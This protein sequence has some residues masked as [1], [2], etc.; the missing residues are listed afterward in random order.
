MVTTGPLFPPDLIGADVVSSF[1]QG[2][3]IRPLERGDY[4]KGFLDCLSVLSDVG[5]VSQDQF[6]ERFDWMKIQGQGVHFHVVIEHENRIVGTGAIIVERKFIHNLGLI[7]HI[8]EIAIGKDFQGKGLGLKLLA[9]LS[10][11]AKNVGCYKTTLGT[12]P[13]NEPFYVKCGYNKSGNIMNQ[14][15]PISTK[16]IICNQISLGIFTMAPHA[17]QDESTPGITRLP[18]PA[19][20]AFSAS[21]PRLLIIGAGNRGKAYAEAIKNASNGVIVGVVEPIAL[22]RRHLGRKYI[23]GTRE[24]TPGEEFSDWPE[25]VEWELSR[26]Q[27][28][29]SGA[30][31]V[32]EGVD[33]VF[34]CVQDGMHK[35]V[36]LGLAPL[37][38]HIMCE[39]P[40]APNLE[41]C[42]AIYN[43]L[44]PD[45]SGCSEK[46]FAI[47]HVLRYSPHNI[48]MR[49][50]LLEDKLIGD[51]MSV[52][53]TE[54]VGWYHFTHSYVRGNWRNEKAAAPSL[55]AKSCHDMDILYWIL[56]ASPPGSNKPTHVPKDISSSGSLQY[57][58]KERKPVEAGNATNCLSCAYEPSC[59]FSAKR[60]YTGADLKSQQQEHFCTVVAPEIEDCVPNS[61]PEIAKKAILSKL[62][63]DYSEDTPA[64]DVSKRN[65]F[66]RCVYECD[67]D[68]CDN[69]V[70]TLSWD[71][72]PV[73]APGETP[74]QALS[75][76]GSKTATLHMVAFTEKICTRFTHIYGVHGEMY[77][78]SSSITV[79]DFRTCKKTVHYPHIPE[80]GGHGD[81]DEGLTRQFVLAVDRV[82]NHGEK[83]STAQR[84]YIKCNLRDVIMSHSMVFAAE[85][86][87]KGRKVVDFQQWFE[88]EVMIKLGA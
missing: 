4:A 48:M 63:E 42:M 30:T 28:A 33:A 76:R 56:A 7:G 26:R 80:G 46:L 88:K 66:G 11:I 72:D 20:P 51:I 62:A 12:S 17:E 6:E 68:V 83:V 39:K 69:Q 36:V 2:Y 29:A 61:D 32:P 84:E 31:D 74:L 47:G 1:P 3:T 21:P 16:F 23:W 24:P 40:L 58:R 38:L 78:D 45:S 9:S 79:T 71:A 18:P 35:D 87:R 73:A 10:S 65:T 67:N 41:D 49:K 81:G 54:P 82:K 37:K 5:N 50:L 13:D 57:F 75:G 43:S 59:Q 8:E 25:F 77:A 19:R 60:I 44:S 55:L 34:V 22:K 53:H 52:N 86:A 85:E 64:E 15:L 14:Y 70:V 27:K